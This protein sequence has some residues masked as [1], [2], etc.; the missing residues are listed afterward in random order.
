MV[1]PIFFMI[2]KP[3]KTA[4]KNTI[5]QLFGV[6]PQPYQPNGHSGVDF[7]APY[8]TW[9]VAPELCKITNIIDTPQK[10]NIDLAPL[11][12][13]Y[14]IVMQSVS[15]PNTYY[16]YW[17][18]MPFFPVEIG[19]T[20]IQGQEVARIGNSGFCMVRGEIVPLDIRNVPPYLGTHLHYEKFIEVNGV[21]TY[22]DVLPD[23]DWTIWNS[24]GVL[25]DIQKIINKILNIFK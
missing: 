19:D 7:F 5:S 1:A 22:F 14:G 20:V 23:I 16:L 21:R 6:N 3:Y 12:R 10:L 15:K 9:L 8:G 25:D 11:E 13:G 18:C 4:S 2:C 17:H 24:N